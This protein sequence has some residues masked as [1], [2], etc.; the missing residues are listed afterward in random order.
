MN[1]AQRSKSR[2]TSPSSEG[3]EP[4]IDQFTARLIRRKAHQ[5]VGRAGFT[6]SDREDIEQELRLKILKHFSSYDP[7]QGHRH[8][9]VTAVVERHAANLLRNKQAEKRD[10]RRVRSLNVAIADEEDEARPR[11][12]GAGGVPQEGPDRARVRVPAPEVDP[13]VGGITPIENEITNLYLTHPC[14]TS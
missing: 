8:A 4:I 13:V 1:S 2:V 14:R 11:L 6:R 9:F 10:H 12:P 3:D 7:Q 5:L